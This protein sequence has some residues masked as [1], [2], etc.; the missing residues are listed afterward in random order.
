MPCVFYSQHG[1]PASGVPAGS[2][3]ASIVSTSGVP[4]DSVPASGVLAGSLPAS[5]V[6]AGS[7]PASGV[8]AGSVPASGV[9]AGSLPASRVPAGGVLAGSINSAEFGVPAANE[10]VPAVFTNDPTATSLLPH[11]HSLGSCEHTT[12]FPSPSDLGNHQPTADIFSSSS[13]DDDF[14]ADVT[15]LALNVVVDPVATKRVNTIH[16]QSQIIGA[17][18]SPVRTRGTVQKSKFGESAFISYVHNHNRTNHA[19]HLHCLFAC[20]LSQL[21]PSSV[22][23]ALE[24][25]DW[26][27]AMKEEMQQ[28]YHQQVWKLVPLPAGKIAIGTKLILKNKRDTRGIVDR[29]HPTFPSICLIHGLYG[30]SNGRQKCLPLWEIEEEVYVTQPKGF[31]DPHNPK[32]VYSVVK[33]LYGLHQAPRTWYYRRA[34]CDEFKVLMKGEFEMSVMGELKFF[35]GLQVKQLH[36]GIFISQDKYVKDVLNM[37]DMDSVRTTTTPYEVPKHKSKGDPDDAVNVY[38]FR[39]MICSLMYL[40][41]SRPDIMFVVSDCSRHQVIPLTSHLNAVKKIFK[42]LKGKPNLGLWY[43]QDSPFQL[44]AYSDSD[45]VGS[46]GDMKSTTGGCQFLGRRLISWQC[47]KQTVV[48]TSS[49]KAKYVVAASCCGQVLNHVVDLVPAGSCITPTGS[50]S[51]MLWTWFLLVVVLFLLYKDDHNKVSYLEKGKGWEAYAQILDFLQKSH[52]R[53]ALTHRPRIMFDSLV[54]QFWATTTVHNHEAGPSQIITN[55]DGNQVV[56][57]ESLIR[58]QLQLNGVDGLYEFTLSDVLDGMRV[59]GYPTDGSLTF[60]NAK[61]SPQWRFLIHILIHCMS[62]KSGGGISSLTTYPSLRPTFDFTAKLFSNMKLNWDGPHMPLL[63]LMLVVPATGDGADAVDADAV[64]AGAAAAHDVL[65]PSVPPIHSSSYI[66]GPSSAPQSSPMREPTPVREPTPRPIREPTPDSLKPPSLPPRSEEVGPT[67]STRPPNLTRQ[68]SFHADISEG[69]SDFVSSPKSNEAPQTLTATTAGG[70]EDS[71]AL[72]ALSLKLDRCIN[73]V[74][75]LDN[76]LGITKQVLGDAI[77]KL[78]TRVKRL[79]GLLQQRK[80]IL[81]LFDTEGDDATLTEQDIDLE[82]LHMLASKSLG[83]DSTDKAADH[84]AAEVP[85]Y[86]TM[87]FRRRRLRKPFTSFP[88]AHVP[89]NILA[90]TGFLAAATIIPAGSSMN[91]AVT[92]AGAPLSSILAVDKGKAPM[93]DES[94]PADLLSEQERILKNLHAYHLGEDLAKNFMQNRRPRLS[95]QRRRELD[96]AQIIYTE[97]D[98][99]ELLVK[100][101]TNS[102]LSKQLLG[103][104]VTEDNMNERLGMLLLRKRRELAAQSRVLASVPAASSFAA[105][106]S[107]SAATPPEVL[108]AESRSA[109]TPTASV[110]VS[111]EPSVAADSGSDDDPLPYAPYAGWKIVPSP[112]GSVHTYS[113]MAGHTKQFTSLRELLHIAE[114]TDLQKLLGTV[115]NLYQREDPDSFALLLWG[116]LNVLFQ[117]LDDEDAH[118]FWRVSCWFLTT[119][120]MVFSS[121]WLTA[122]KEL[123]HHEGT[124]LSW[125]VQEQTALGKDESNPLTVG[126]LLKTTWSSIHHLLINEVLTSPEQTTTG[127]D[128]S[129]LFMAMMVCQKPLGYFSSPM[130]HVP[131]AELVFNPPGRLKQ[132]FIFEKSPVDTMADQRTIAELLRAPIEGYAEAIVI[133]PILAEHFKLKHSITNMMTSDQFFRLEKDNPHD[134][135]RW[136]EM[137]TSIQASMSNQTNEL[138]NMMARFFQIN[139][140]STLGSGPLPSNTI[141]NPK[142]ELNSITTRSGIVLEGPSIPMCHPFINLEEDERV[143]ETLTCLELAEYTIKVPPPLVQKPKPPSQRNF[144]KMLKA[145]LSNKEKLLELENTPLNENCLAAILNRLPKKLGDPGKFLNLCGFSELKCKALAD[146]GASI[147]LMPLLG[148]EKVRVPLI[149]GRPF[150]RTTRALIDVHREEM[151]LHL[152]ATNHLSGNPTFSSHIDLTSS[153]VK[154]DIF[155]L[156]GDIILDSTKDLPIPHNINPLSGSTTSSSSSSSLDRL[157]EEFADE[158]ALITFLSGNDDLSFP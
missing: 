81:V 120:Q 36:D 82:A 91:A 56:V 71:A 12:R 79:E 134:H 17:L 57:T 119:P 146:L 141:A 115:D 3:P 94:L 58:T 60:Y 98:W 10:S 5:G 127:K 55:I 109:D 108:A 74:T 70:A 14:C 29:S 11:S 78:V 151:I 18:Q 32:H 104:D 63:A 155:D 129:N 30:L 47:T 62:P 152:F 53:Y 97:A 147:N 128:V 135:I 54:K 42:Y 87:P 132:P 96:A 37:F 23:K 153:K 16:P 99:L 131:R 48:A 114:R 116:D 149:L 133:P 2:L 35:L 28:F 112:L 143:E 154:D 121:P 6:L 26:V 107:V 137:K 101:A 117:S 80:Q 33:A 9:P 68:S 90:G 38:L 15:N 19:D 75:S 148:L 111:V 52:I 93:V 144:M 110:H 84:D 8:P 85:T 105:D 4:A 125:L 21:E 73:R 24:Y 103:D 76:E 50:Y 118:D 51:F 106:V 65:P 13:Y 66:P 86:A 40:T 113:D 126:S 61:L 72:T 43:P 46:H 49:T 69:G 140:A 136:N 130:I 1:V 138:K 77:L 122:E 92:V 59:I 39:S 102:A 123:T 124:A 157:L 67:T 158:L 156:E 139:T 22:G 20:F 145:L 7:L 64:V 142:G 41:A 27:V 89:E 45:Y 31:E 150:L 34:W 44:E 95:D 100:I 83:G 88:S 25:P